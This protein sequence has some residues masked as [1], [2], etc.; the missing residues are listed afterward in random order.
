MVLGVGYVYVSVRASSD[1]SR[2]V[3]TSVAA[4]RALLGDITVPPPPRYKVT[5]RAELL[6]A[7]V[8]AIGDVDVSIPIDGDA[9][10][11]V[12]PAVAAVLALPIYTA[13]ASPLAEEFSVRVELLDA[14]V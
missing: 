2:I 9:D 5:V 7:V 3:E 14:V 11:N 8:Q 1:M 13:E 12:E 10:W 4:V 6:D